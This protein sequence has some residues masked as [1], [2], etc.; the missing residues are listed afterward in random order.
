MRMKRQLDSK[1]DEKE[2]VVNDSMTTMRSKI[3]LIIHAE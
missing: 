2:F 1:I 3:H